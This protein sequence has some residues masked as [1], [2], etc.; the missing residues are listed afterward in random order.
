[1]H[2]QYDAVLTV[3]LVVTICSDRQAGHAFGESTA[4]GS[5]FRYEYAI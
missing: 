3:L 1:V 4:A 5:T 2:R